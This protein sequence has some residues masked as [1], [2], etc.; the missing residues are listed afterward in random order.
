MFEKK[1][2][3]VSTAMIIW[4]ILLVVI[5]LIIAYLIYYLYKKIKNK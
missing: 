1:I 3:D 5:F 2:E 4:Q